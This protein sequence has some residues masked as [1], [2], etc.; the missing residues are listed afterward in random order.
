M[1]YRISSHVIDWMIENGLKQPTA[2]RAPRMQV[3]P[4]GVTPREQQQQQ[5][6]YKQEQRKQH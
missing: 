4:R 5:R 6:K 3:A 1:D 2:P